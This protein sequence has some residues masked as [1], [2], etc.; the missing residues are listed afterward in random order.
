MNMKKRILSFG[1]G[2]VLAVGSLT[3]C[4][5]NAGSGSGVKK[6][7]FM[8]GGDVY[9]A[10]MYNLLIDTYNSTAGKEQGI[11]VKGIPKLSNLESILLQ[12]LPTANG[13][14]V[15]ALEDT[16]FKKF[17][18]YLE[19][20]TDKVDSEILDDFYPDII[21]RYHYNI[22]T[23][24][25]NSDDPLYSLPLFNNTTVLYYN[26]TA[27]E[28]AGVICISV[29]EEN[30]KEFNEGKA[31]DL[32]GKTKAD[33][34]ISSVV[35]AKGFF[36]SETPFVPAKNEI[37]G[38][39]WYEPDSGEELIFNDR[40]PMNWDEIEDL[41]MICTETFNP[42][43]ATKYG[44][45]TQWWFNYG[46]SV[47]GDCMEDTSGNGDWT[48]AL[49]GDIP[50]YIV[51]EGKTY[52]GV[53][54]GTTYNAGDTL[55]IKDIV[56]AKAGDKIS[57]STENSTDFY[58]TVNGAKAT[59]RDLGGEIAGGV[60]QELPSIKDAFSR[61]C[62]LAGTGGLNVSPY[63]SE[64]TDGSATSY[65]TSGHLALMVERVSNLKAVEK[66][67]KDD[68]GIAPLPQ[69][70]TYTEPDNPQCDTVAT[71]GK[72]ATHS[73][74]ISAAVNAKSNVKDE[75]Y[76]FVEWIATE[77]QKVLAENGYVSARKSDEKLVLETL[78][79]SN[80][81]IIVDSVKN[82]SPGDWWYMPDKNWIDTWSNPLNNELRYGKMSFD[83]FIYAYIE[84][85]NERL[86][87]YKQ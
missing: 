80:P 25:S 31:K 63:P 40:I 58:Y 14:D 26:K 70:K 83:E 35:P 85:T 37:D 65:F 4:A 42:N 8:F 6:V 50:N 20:L 21:R 61:F 3:G 55:D 46:W 2:L 82:S 39:S 52:K 9:D 22:Q 56:N 59:V 78:P 51:Q 15:V 69:Y 30:L 33:Y 73:H 67:M 44:Y 62:Y 48:F 71:E 75:A 18:K 11:E 19:D 28:D 53:Y 38:S 66:R 49:A 1:L 5:G 34:D 74:G 47:G 41:A 16:S 84:T 76:K 79:Y 77:G 72:V 17:T 43:S 60:L 7:N 36:R 64:L 68:W 86:A 23:T 12:Q 29:D 81:K 57:Y 13:P 27:L 32:N 45:Y 24:T 54:T 87:E 10:E